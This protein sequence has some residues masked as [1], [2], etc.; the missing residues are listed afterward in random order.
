MHY[1][2]VLVW[3]PRDFKLRLLG[4]RTSVDI[5]PRIYLT[6]VDSDLCDKLDDLLNLYVKWYT[7]GIE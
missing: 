1:L 3:V 4:I 5:P 6:P 2:G 7:T